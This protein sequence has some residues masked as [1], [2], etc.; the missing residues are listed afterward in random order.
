M[1]EWILVLDNANGHSVEVEGFKEQ[2]SRSTKGRVLITTRNRRFAFSM[3]QASDIVDMPAMNSNDAKQL[4]DA[5]SVRMLGNEHSG[6]ADLVQYLGYHPSAILQAARYMNTNYLSSSE[7]VAS[8][9]NGTIPLPAVLGLDSTTIA[10]PGSLAL[11]L[12]QSTTGTIIARYLSLLSCLDHSH[13]SSELLSRVAC[14]SEEKHAV[15]LM[16][17]YY[18]LRPASLQSF[19][20]LDSLIAKLVIA[21]FPKRADRCQIVVSAL[22]IVAQLLMHSTDGRQHQSTG[23]DFAHALCVLHALIRFTAETEVL[24]ATVATAVVVATGV[25]RHLVL[26]GRAS[27]AIGIIEQLFLW[28]QFSPSFQQIVQQTRRCISKRWVARAGICRH[29]KRVIRPVSAQ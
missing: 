21:V 4:L 10:N 25:C 1:H 7:L 28:G 22:D 24:P 23:Q 3:V 5:S 13:L 11:D 6:D 2:L 17:S 18:M 20:Q 16:K 19:L 9:E 26:A 12:E 15:S 27:E 8:L 29:A 14:T